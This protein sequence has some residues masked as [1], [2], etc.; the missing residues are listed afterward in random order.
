M[1]QFA[2]TYSFYSMSIVSFHDSIV[3]RT[4]EIAILVQL[5]LFAYSDNF[6]LVSFWLLCSLSGLTI[7]ANMYYKML[8]NW[9]SQKVKDTYATRNAF[10]F[11]NGIPTILVS[12]LE[13]WR[14]LHY[15]FGQCMLSTVLG[16]LVSDC[17]IQF[18][19]MST[20]INTEF[21]KSR[22]CGLSWF[23]SIINLWECVKLLRSIFKVS[24][25]IIRK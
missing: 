25:W 9:T 6:L 11:K 8:I 21:L 20:K 23:V 15:C 12:Q 2:D 19:S 5:Y 3:T 18:T 13:G 17:L 1:F 7:Q 4:I 24:P 14:L 10:E 22:A 16:M